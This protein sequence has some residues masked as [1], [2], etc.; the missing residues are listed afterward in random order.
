MDQ[1]L[2]DLRSKIDA[3]D[4]KIVKLINERY[5]HV[6][7]VGK[8]KKGCSHAIYVPEREKAVFENLEKINNGPMTNITLRA[9]YREIMSGAI[10]L[11]HPLRVGFFGLEAS[12]THLA[13]MAKFG[14]SV[15]YSHKNSISDVFNDLEADR[16]DYGCVPIENSTEGAVN[17]TLDMFINSNA[18]ICSEI[19]MRIHHNLMAKCSKKEIKKVYSHI[20]V[21]SQ[22]R[23]WLQENL[24]GVEIVE[25]ANSTKAAETAAREKYSAAI[26]SSLAAEIYKLK[27]LAE[28]IED[29]PDNTT[30]FMI[31]G[32]QEPKKTG[33]DK[34]SICFALKDRVGALYDSLLPFKNQKITLTMIESRPSK[35][36]N[37][38]Y[39]FFIDMLGHRTDPKIQKA[40]DELEGMSQ[41]M[42]VL[43]SYP[44]FNTNI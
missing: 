30:R 42:R 10:A 29:I 8:W 5:R 40:L 33:D 27:I 2:K 6:L 14:H 7:D 12:Y 37:W 43:G 31:I 36:K 16:I 23:C 1:H 3:I 38:E 4:R 22:C 18:K 35:K 9:V 15:D 13:A 39:Y 21:L 24:P 41:A 28:N 44:R 20:Q 26:S 25:A 19:N 11:E 34:T 32:K 17:H